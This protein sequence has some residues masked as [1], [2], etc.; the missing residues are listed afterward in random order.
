MMVY[1]EMKSEQGK[2]IRRIRS[3]RWISGIRH[4]IAFGLRAL[5]RHPA[6]VLIPTLSTG[7]GIGA[8]SLVFA[9]TNFAFFRP[10]PVASGQAL[11][12]ITGGNAK[13]GE[14]G[15]AI[16]YPDFL[17]MR[18]LRS[19]KSVAAYFPM[20]PAAISIDGSEPRRYW[21]TIASA[22]YFDVVRCG[23]SP[24]RGFDPQLDDVPG[25]PP[26]IVIS[27][28][29]W[30]SRLNADLKV[31]GHTIIFNNRSLTIIGIA[32]PHFVGTDVALASDFWIPFSLRDLVTPVLPTSNIDIFADRNARWLFGLTRLREGATI[33]Q[34]AAELR[35]TA[36]RLAVS[37]PTTNRDHSLHIELA[38]QVT[39]TVRHAILRFF[40]LLM[41]VASLVLVTVCANT[42]NL[43]LA[44]GYSRRQEIATRMALGAE[45]LRLIRQMLIESM[46]LAMPGGVLGCIITCIGTYGLARLPLPIDLPLNLDV[47][48]DWRVMVFCS[49]LSTLIGL[50]FGTASALHL[51]K[52][53]I[54]AGLRGQFSKQHGIRWLNMRNL[55]VIIQT[56]VCALL[57]TC[58]GLFLHSLKSSL[59]A[60]T[61]MTHQNVGIISFDP[62]LQLASEE[63]DRIAENIL[64][65]V[66]EIPGIQ[67]AAL[68]TSV[69]LSL[70]GV[71]GSVTRSDELRGV[72]RIR[73]PVDIY[74]VSPGFFD[75]LGIQFLSGEDFRS[76]QRHDPVVI[77][78][79]AAAERLFPGQNAVGRQ[80]ETDGK[81]SL[82]IIGVVKTS[83][84]RSIV[85]TPRSCIYRPLSVGDV[86]SIT[87]VIIL[88]RTAGNPVNFVRPVSE[89]IRHVD[90]GVALFNIQTMA[91]HLSNALL[92]QRVAAF[93]FVTMALIGLLIASLG[94]YGLLNFLVSRQ[95]KEIGIRMAIGA[96]R[97]QILA[98]VLRRGMILTI[99]GILIGVSVAI[100]VGKGV[101]SF[102]YG[103]T[104]TDLNTFLVVPLLLVAI[105]ILACLVPAFRAAN[106]NP[107]DAIRYE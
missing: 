5:I 57:L 72:D 76:G 18:E 7:I 49:V 73:I 68:T 80:I 55:L 69:P 94:L 30:T 37:Y 24:G 15:S 10:L 22:N 26:V 90:P 74:D 84:S 34:A 107:I 33:E 38:G 8:C 4:D 91:E 20:M 53:D 99:A 19:F 56:A 11:M 6:L 61:G 95:T 71:S 17:D 23:V 77:L 96:S 81:Q 36:Q 93:L 101:A 66:R 16:S 89:T 2:I 86:H 40:I 82:R 13:T 48:L 31:L 29:F 105:S 67:S 104:S 32:P 9:V 27:H 45:R 14:V 106:I 47:S 98:D 75:T 70:A 46:L 97:Q 35:V 50:A 39:P 12:S 64:Q 52:Q 78:N 3:S 25:A 51:I 44:R 87:G 83:K 58:A 42:V 85:E 100:L 65:A 41:V 103:V 102:L 1:L 54:V 21:G 62:T 79:W 28:R 88:F 60:P 43:L 92:F 59:S 63:R